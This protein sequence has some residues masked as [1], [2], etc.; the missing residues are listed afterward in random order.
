MWS[1]GR[2]LLATERGAD[3]GRE[4]ERERLIRVAGKERRSSGMPHGR[5]T[6]SSKPSP[7]PQP[8]RSLP[9][10]PPHPTAAVPVSQGSG[11][12]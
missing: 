12:A 2:E 9:V 1:L 5:T 4:A 3:L 11:Q 8:A 7:S 6:R 10:P